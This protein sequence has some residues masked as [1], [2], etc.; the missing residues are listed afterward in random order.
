MNTPFD[1]VRAAHARV[2]QAVSSG[3]IPLTRLDEA[4]R[5]VLRAK[6]RFSLFE[7]PLPE[8]ALAAS[9]VGN[10]EDRARIND[11]IARSVTLARDDA[12]LVPLP[13]GAPL[14]VVETPYAYGLSGSLGQPGMRVSD[15]PTPGEIATA[16]AQSQ[17][18]TVLVTTSNVFLHPAQ[19]DLVRALVAANVPVIAWAVKGPFDVIALRD[20]P[21]LTIVATYGTPPYLLIQPMQALLAGQMQAQGQLPMDG[22]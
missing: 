14:F 17:G 20:V 10:A 15:D 22:P 19:A 18:R 6:E 1:Q 12:A 3:E 21:S 7:A 4:V 16:V 5:R 9:L 11:I 8:P 2:V 13:P